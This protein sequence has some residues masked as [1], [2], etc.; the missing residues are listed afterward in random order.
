MRS[1]Q[2]TK[3]VVAQAGRAA[4]ATAKVKAKLM[5]CKVMRVSA[6][7]ELLSVLDERDAARKQRD[8][9]QTQ[10][11]RLEQEMDNTLQRA[12]SNPSRPYHCCRSDVSGRTRV[13]AV[14][15]LS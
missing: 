10:F 11:E 15:A 6:E 5:H 8:A 14:H 13:R 4:H 3:E 1:V 2:E 9:L 7:R 12:Y